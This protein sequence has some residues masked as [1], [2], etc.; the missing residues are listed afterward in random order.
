MNNFER[1][2]G[3]FSITNLTLYLIIARVAV[4][5]IG[6]FSPEFV[7]YLWYDADAIMSGQVWRLV[8]Y[9]FVANLDIWF[10]FQ[11]LFLYF[12]GTAL[13]QEWGYFKYTMY[14][15]MSIL[16]VVIATLIIHFA[17]IS[18]GSFILSAA[19]PSLFAY[20]LFLPFAW[21]YGEHEIMLM[22]MLPVKVKYL[23]IVDVLL[24]IKLFADTSSFPQLWI[25]LVLS[26]LNLVVFYAVM[27]PQRGKQV[28]R[29][30][31]FKTKA[32]KAER[33]IKKNAIHR[34]R[35]CGI[36]EKDDPGMSFR[37]CSK[38]EGDYEFC[39]KHLRE[40]EHYKKVVDFPGA[41]E[42]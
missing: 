3:R 15:L 25:V 35:V 28:K 20:S 12:I 41:H 24:I 40:H 21:Y 38:C 5:V 10:L 4:A 39:E 9:M 7:G 18:S 22:G 23:A 19:L 33:D 26:L 36:T 6:I 34:C 31:D 11:L 30:A 8:T 42:K 37:Y 29:L 16:G 2:F 32:Y 1:K 27:L 17:N 14:F 13:E